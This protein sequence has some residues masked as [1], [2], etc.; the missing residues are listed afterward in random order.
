MSLDDEC[1]VVVIVVIV[2]VVRAMWEGG[3]LGG[4]GDGDGGE[5][6][7]GEDAGADSSVINCDRP[8]KA[9]P[10]SNVAGAGDNDVEAIAVVGVNDDDINVVED[11]TGDDDGKDDC[12]DRGGE[13]SAAGDSDWA[14]ADGCDGL[15]W[16]SAGKVS[17]RQMRRFGARCSTITLLGLACAAL[18]GLSLS[19]FPACCSPSDMTP[20][21]L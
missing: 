4:G 18:L 9:C 1:T 10:R 16:L 15:G 14:A 12:G 13:G 7:A 19:L 17:S 20:S 5:G 3:W 6:R 8:L 2:V 21:M 11:D